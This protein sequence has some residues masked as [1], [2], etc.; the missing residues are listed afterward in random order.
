MRG[1]LILIASI[2]LTAAYLLAACSTAYHLDREQDRNDIKGPEDRN[3][4]E[5]KKLQRWGCGDYIDGCGF[6][7][8]P[9]KLTA[10]PDT[11]SG[12]VE[13][14]DTVNYALYRIVGLERRWDWGYDDKGGYPYAITLG[15]DGTAS[16]YDFSRVM[17]DGDG[18]RRTKPADLLKCHRVRK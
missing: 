5:A 11:S 16:Y 6:R 2:A 3:D 4:I 14:A 15:T 18:V 10:D 13:V 1:R 9:I 7:G 8:C 17:A 12:T